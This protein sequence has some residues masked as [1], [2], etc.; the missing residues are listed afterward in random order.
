MN[1]IIVSVVNLPEVNTSG[2]TV[3]E[4]LINAADAID[5][6]FAGR[7]N[8]GEEIPLVHTIHLWREK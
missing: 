5:E 4:A 7:I 2:E 3:Q 6:A 8:R 1:D